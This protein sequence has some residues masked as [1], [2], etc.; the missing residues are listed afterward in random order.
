MKRQCRF[1]ERI[2]MP[3]E[4]ITKHDLERLSAR[5][6]TSESFGRAIKAAALAAAARNAET[7]TLGRPISMKMDVSVTPVMKGVAYVCVGIQDVG[8]FCTFER[9]DTP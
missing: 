7:F 2:H 1:K 5:A 3:E 4:S 9:D 6:H 8:R